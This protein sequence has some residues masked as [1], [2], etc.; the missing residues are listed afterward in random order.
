MNKNSSKPNSDS[1]QYF[2]FPNKEELSIW[3]AELDELHFEA[4]HKS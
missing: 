3:K 1:S 2:I 4:L